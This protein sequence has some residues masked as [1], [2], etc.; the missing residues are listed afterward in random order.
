M[1]QELAARLTDFSLSIAL[2]FIHSIVPVISGVKIARVTNEE[3]AA[4]KLDSLSFQTLRSKKDTALIHSAT[5][6]QKATVE[7][8]PWLL[9][10]ILQSGRENH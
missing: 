3:G 8:K 4:F 7:P 10:R 6:M 9:S 5:E 2:F 1:V